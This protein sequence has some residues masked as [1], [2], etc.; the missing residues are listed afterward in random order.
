MHL[1][2]FQIII[3]IGSAV[4]LYLR[5]IEHLNNRKSNIALHKAITKY[6]L[7]NFNLYIYEYLDSDINSVNLKN[8]TE[9]ETKYI[10]LFNFDTLYN[11]KAIATSMLGYKHTEE[12]IAKMIKRL[13]KK[14]NHPMF[15]KKHTDEA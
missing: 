12:A 13:E 9:L 7:N 8:L 1:R 14:E 3:N 4:N 15:G 6:G 2:I 11:F 5:I 10:S